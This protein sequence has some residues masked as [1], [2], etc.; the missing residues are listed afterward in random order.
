MSVE[1]GPKA[2]ILVACEQTWQGHAS[3]FKKIQLVSS[4]EVPT[5]LNQCNGSPVVE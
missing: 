4:L 1:I 5:S 3:C 2:Y